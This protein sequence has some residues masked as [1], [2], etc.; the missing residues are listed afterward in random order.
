[1]FNAISSVVVGWLTIRARVA[2]LAVGWL[3]IVG[4]LLNPLS[5][6]TL[7]GLFTILLGI[8][9]GLTEAVAVAA[10]GWTLV[11]STRHSQAG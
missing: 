4:G 11:G 10:Y 5:G 3:L 6:L 8:V 7:V 1:M 2:P 9:S